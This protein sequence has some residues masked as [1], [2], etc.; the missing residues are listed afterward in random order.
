MYN[1]AMGTKNVSLPRD[2]EEYI[3]AKVA[4]GEYAHASE[5]VRDGVRLLMRQEAEKLEWLRDAIAEGV[6]DL[7]LG[8]VI[9]GDR[10]VA[11]VKKMGRALLKA[12]RRRK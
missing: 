3:D 1:S 4:S 12:R 11:E 6:A 10:I 5:V 2:L 9:P 8:N 7:E